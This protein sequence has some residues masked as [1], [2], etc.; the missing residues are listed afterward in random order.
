MADPAFTW[1]AVFED[2]SIDDEGDNVFSVDKS[3]GNVDICTDKG[4]VRIGFNTAPASASA[5][6]T[7]GQII[8]AGNYIYRCIATDTR[9]RFTGATL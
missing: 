7:A 8:F 2:I 1:T 9:I 5:T 6:G 3:T 4:L